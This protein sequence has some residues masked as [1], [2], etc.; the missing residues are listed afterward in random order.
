MNR[1]DHQSITRS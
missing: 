1:R